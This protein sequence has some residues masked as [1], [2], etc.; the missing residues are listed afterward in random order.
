[1]RRSLFGYLEG[2]EGREGL[3]LSRNLAKHEEW[4]EAILPADVQMGSPEGETSRRPLMGF[5]LVACLALGALVVRLFVLQ[6]LGGSDN[7]ALA[8][9]NRIRQQVARAPR[10]MIYDRNHAV[11]A[12]NQ[13]SYDVTVVPQQ[14][15]ESAADRDAVYA[16]LGAII[17]MS[18]ADVKAKAEVTCTKHEPDCLRSP[19][20]ELVV[21]GVDHDKALLAEQ[22]AST[23]PGFALDVNPIRQYSDNDLL[24]AFLGYTGRVNADEAATDPSYGPTDLIGKSGLE[25]Q[26]EEQLRGTNGGTRTEVDA[27]GRPIHVLESLDPIPGNN[28]VLSIDGDLQRHMV[29]AITKQMGASGAVRAA[30]VAVNPKSGEVLA[31]ASLPSYDDNKFSQGIS[32]ADY[33]KLLNDPGQPLFNKAVSGGYPSGSIIKPLG[34]AAAL[35]EH[36]ISSSTVINDTGKI[37]IP[38]K[39]DPEHPA[40]Y[41]GWERTSGLGPV[42]VVSALAQSS[43]IFF[44]EVMGG[45]TDFLHYMGIDRLASYYQKFGLGAKTGIDLPGETPGRVPTPDWKKAFS[46]TDWYTGDTYNV[47]VGQGDLLVSPLQMAMA[48]SAIANGGTLYKPRLVSS[49]TDGNGKVVKQTQAQVVRQNFIDPADLALVR[50]G[51]IA[52]V[53]TPSGTACCRIAQEVPVKVAAK[54]GTAETVTHDTGIGAAQQSK[55]DAWFEAFAPADNPQ[56][57]VVILVEHSGEGA[58]YAAPAARE[59]LTWYFTQGAGAKH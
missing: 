43:D 39:Y 17:G 37:V 48:V 10:G 47:S 15:P 42:N 7:L 18:A 54:T 5:G 26:Y 1:M 55:P 57:V 23:L 3:R 2:N 44:Y 12:R 27:T 25:K 30:G 14:L 52:A 46:G 51:M 31:I 13:A 21:S 50:Q 22:S 28:L 40:T 19:V 59:I 6:V 35:N 9:G 49:I 34:A 29:D 11:L 36:V 38:N 4:T 53:N 58:E 56:I 8:N 41:L 33:Q 45:F 20:P 32:Q 16:R 24:S